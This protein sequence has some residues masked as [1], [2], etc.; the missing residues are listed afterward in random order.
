LREQEERL[1]ERAGM[2]RGRIVI[3]ILKFVLLLAIVIGVPTYILIWNHSAIDDL[4]SFDDIVRYLREYKNV[5]VLIYLG[6]QVLQIMISVLPGQAFQFAAGYLFGFFP[7]LLYSIIGA[8][9]GT[10]VTYYLARFLGEDALC[11]FLGKEKMKKYTEW[12]NGPKAYLITFLIYLIPGMPKDLMCYAAGTSRIK[13]KAFLF[14]SVVGRTP[15]MC[16]SIVFGSMYMK[17]NYVGMA[18]FGT[19]CL[20]A[21]V[22]CLIKKEKLKQLVSDLYKKLSE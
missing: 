3:S 9:M 12:L 15:A 20:V 5:S 14:L 17:G 21:L 7:A 18:V 2:S 19:I 4:N 1:E 8:I 22:I 11:F 13:F 6:A 16:G 10:T